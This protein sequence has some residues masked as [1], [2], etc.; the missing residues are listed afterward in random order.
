[1][2]SVEKFKTFRLCFSLLQFT[3]VVGSGAQQ[4]NCSGEF[5]RARSSNILIEI[6]MCNY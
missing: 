5:A 1:M 3:V 2:K 4:L 6:S